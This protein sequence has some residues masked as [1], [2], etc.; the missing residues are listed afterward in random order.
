MI[1]RRWKAF[2][3]TT[4]KLD[5]IYKGTL[6]SRPQTSEMQGYSQRILVWLHINSTRAVVRSLAFFS[7]APPFSKNESELTTVK[8]SNDDREND[9]L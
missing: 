3:S 8:N 5:A 9:K 4:Q 1:E 6:T 7:L 2:R